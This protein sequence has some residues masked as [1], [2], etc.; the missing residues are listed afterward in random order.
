M[1][2]FSVDVSKLLNFVQCEINN[3]IEGTQ[4]K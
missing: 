3:H 1:F 4:I 2:I